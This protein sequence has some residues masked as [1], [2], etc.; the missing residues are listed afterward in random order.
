[1]TYK[2][3]K[4]DSSLIL[5]LCWVVVLLLLWG[6]VEFSNKK[7]NE[8]KIKEA[9]RVEVVTN[10][11]DVKGLYPVVVRVKKVD[12]NN[13]DEESNEIDGA[14]KA[15]V[16]EVTEKIVVAPVDYVS[17][18]KEM[19]SLTGTG[20][21]GAFINGQFFRLGDIVLPAIIS[22]GAVHINPVLH[23]VGKDEATLSFNNRKIKFIL[24]Q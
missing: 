20:N 7:L 1:M 5:I 21:D 23:S 8:L 11:I 10:R 14:F 6:C 9:P 17:Q 18:I 24:S 2:K 4:S 13:K 15:A 16:E 12:G 19:V 22:D 3:T